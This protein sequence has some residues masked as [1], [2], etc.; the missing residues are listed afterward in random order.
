M[1]SHLPDL[2][3][4]AGWLDLYAVVVCGLGL[5]LIVLVGAFVVF[6]AVMAARNDNENSD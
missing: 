2:L 4:G 1:V 6:A 5:L 3:D